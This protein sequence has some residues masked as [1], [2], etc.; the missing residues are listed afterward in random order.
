MASSSLLTLASTTCHAG[1]VYAGNGRFAFGLAPP[2]QRHWCV[3]LLLSSIVCLHCQIYVVFF[4]RPSVDKIA[5]SFGFNVA[6]GGA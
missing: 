5:P 6:S 3:S 1:R 4:E 2:Q